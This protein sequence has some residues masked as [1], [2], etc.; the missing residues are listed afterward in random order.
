MDFLEDK[1]KKAEEAGDLVSALELWGQ[2]ARNSRDPVF[3]LSYGRVAQKLE[4]WDEAEY[5]Y[6]QAIRL[7]P[8]HALAFE[9]MGDLWASRTDKNDAKSFKLAEEWF[10]KALRIERNARTLT[11]LGCA[12]NASGE[13]FA[14]RAAFAEAVTIDPNY[15]EALYHIAVLDE[16][17]D[18]QRSIDLLERAI[19]IDPRYFRAHLELGKLYH[20]RRDLPRAEY[21]FRRCLEI[22]PADEMSLLYLANDLAVQGRLEEAEQQYRMAITMHAEAK[23]VYEF[24]ANFLD[25]VGRQQEAI[26]VR[27]SAAQNTNLQP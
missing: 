7:D 18:P 19:A 10:L 21:H 8:T 23:Q 13:P 14:A 9:L 27:A 11:L 22:D 15:E 26:A 20:R 24:F 2:L 1:A 5:A 6:A 25:S 12:Y 17:V 3:F 16:K 4:K